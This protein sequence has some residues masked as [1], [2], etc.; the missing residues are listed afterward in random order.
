MND[1]RNEAEV[2]ASKKKN[3]GKAAKAVVSAALS[4]CLIA[5]LSPKT[6]R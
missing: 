5:S 1:E 6:G 4:G 3:S 2:S